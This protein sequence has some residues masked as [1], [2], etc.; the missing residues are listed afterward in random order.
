[1]TK[2]RKGGQACCARPLGCNRCFADPHLNL[3]RGTDNRHGRGRTIYSVALAV[4]ISGLAP[5]LTTFYWTQVGV[6][7]AVLGYTLAS[8]CG[9]LW[10]I[11]GVVNN[12]LH[13]DAHSGLL[14]NP[15]LG[16]RHVLCQQSSS[17][18]S[19]TVRFSIHPAWTCPPQGADFCSAWDDPEFVEAVLRLVLSRLVDSQLGIFAML[20]F[21]I[22]MYAVGALTTK[23]AAPAHLF[24]CMFK[25]PVGHC[26]SR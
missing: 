20:N 1:M 13:G 10:C 18:G 6:W 4:S 11:E 3:G 21:A 2:H 12:A 15:K 7:Q 24:A 14:R 16:T 17:F 22:S 26:N 23:V 8:S 5:Q 9:L 19:C 25:L